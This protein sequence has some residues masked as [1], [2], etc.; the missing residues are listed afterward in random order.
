VLATFGLEAKTFGEQANKEMHMNN[1]LGTGAAQV[2][3]ATRY[4]N[5]LTRIE[6]MMTQ[7]LEAVPTDRA[8]PY[9]TRNRLYELALA[10]VYSGEEGRKHTKPIREILHRKVENPAPPFGML[11]MDPWEFCDV[12]RHFE[13]DKI[14]QDYPACIDHKFMPI[15]GTNQFGS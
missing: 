4:P 7:A 9:R 6:T 11:E 13:Q 2:A 12:L 10:L 8:I 14:V 1:S 3:A 5:S 15:M